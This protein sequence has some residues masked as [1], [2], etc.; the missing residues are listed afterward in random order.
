MPLSIKNPEADRLARALASQTGETIT[1][2]VINAL[3]DRLSRQTRRIDELESRV[4]PWK[5]A[6]ITCPSLCLMSAAQ[7]KSWGMTTLIAILEQE[8]EAEQH[9][10]GSCLRSASD[11]S[12]KKPILAE[13]SQSGLTDC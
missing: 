8:S 11:H 9:G 4:M 13:Q 1:Q 10:A 5:S 3:R 6:T 7:T 2:A 12:D